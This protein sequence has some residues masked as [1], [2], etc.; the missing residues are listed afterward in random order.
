M[1]HTKAARKC[2]FTCIICPVGC[3][4]SVKEDHG[5]EKITVSGNECPRGEKY[6]LSEY[7]NPVRLLTTTLRINHGGKTV[8]LPVKTDAPIRK[9]I[10]LAAMEEIK[11]YKTERIVLSAP[12]TM[13][14]V[15]VRGLDVG[16]DGINLVACT[17][18]GD[19]T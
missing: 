5:G 13:G 9:G 7:I 10:I 3:S 16:G 14:D 11:R 15:V 12:V 2:E 19:T 4:L 6:A 1:S 17:D 18:M 8:L